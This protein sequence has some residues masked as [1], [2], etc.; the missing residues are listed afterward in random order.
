MDRIERYRNLIIKAITESPY[1]RFL[2]S[3]PQVDN[4][5]I[6]DEKNNQFMLH[7]TGWEDKQPVHNTILLIRIKEGKIWI[8]ED[9]T[10]E[11]VAT[12][13]LRW[14]VPPSD[15]VYAFTHPSLRVEITPLIL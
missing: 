1:Y 5:F 2:P 3:Q 12:D 14:G 9:W 7:Q 15:I 6:C 10:E 13:L 8:D 11:G 4:L